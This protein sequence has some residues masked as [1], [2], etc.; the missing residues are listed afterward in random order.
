MSVRKV[1]RIEA[2]ATALVFVIVVCVTYATTV[3]V[4]DADRGPSDT[5]QIGGVSLPPVAQ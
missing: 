1:R 5:L 3:C 4:N 2:L